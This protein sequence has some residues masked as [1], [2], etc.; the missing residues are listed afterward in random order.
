MRGPSLITDIET[1]PSGS[2]SDD[3][4]ARKA[5]RRV[6]ARTRRNGLISARADAAARVGAATL[7]PI[8]RD[9]VVAGFHPRDD[10][11]DV[12][13]LLRRLRTEGHDI[14]L[15]VVRGRAQPLLFCVW[16]ERVPLVPA[17]MGILEPAAS[18]E[19]VTPDVLLVPLLEFDGDGY[20]LGYGGGFYDRTLLALRDAGDIVAIGVGFAGQRVEAVPRGPHD[21]PLDW[22][23]TEDG[24]MRA[25]PTESGPA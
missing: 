17:G 6:Q 3:L 2:D 16:D 14:A 24:L 25:E 9:A 5:T 13:P 20:R 10:E 11:F 21:Q 1:R 15:P 22:L 8:R 12:V 19:A 18:C 23:L 4:A 7:P